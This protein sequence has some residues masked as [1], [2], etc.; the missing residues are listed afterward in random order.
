MLNYT[1][2]HVVISTLRGPFLL[3][4]R[5][6]CLSSSNNIHYISFLNINRC[7]VEPERSVTF[8]RSDGL[9]RQSAAA[10]ARGD[11]KD[12]AADSGWHRQNRHGSQ[13]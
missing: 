5:N 7:L 10:A 13:S 9:S 11:E 3:Y 6:F 8:E 2:S 4:W 12:D 1:L